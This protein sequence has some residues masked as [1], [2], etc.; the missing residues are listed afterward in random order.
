[1]TMPD[2]H[3]PHTRTRLPVGEQ[4]DAPARRPLRTLGTVLG[5]VLLLIAALAVAN[6]LGGTSSGKGGGTAAAGG[7]GDAASTPTAP[8]GTTPVTT[9]TGGI[10][11]GY[12]DDA[13]G[14]QSAAANYAVALNSTA[15]Y[16]AAPRQEIVQTVTD[17]AATAHLLSVLD[18]SFT[19][20]ARTLGLGSDGAAPAGLTFVSRPIPVGTKLDTYSAAA[21]T[22][23]VWTNGL[24][25]LAGT[26][27]TN[28]VT[29]YWYTLTFQLRWTG[30]D[31]KIESYSQKDGPVPVS[32]S[33]TVSNSD[34]ISGAVNQF[35]GF[36]Y[37][38]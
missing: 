37:A 15:M 4:T 9:T 20:A 34:T 6:R 36:R 12:H 1:M 2:D 19:S 18:A 27:S 16:A 23:E 8:S 22:V 31:W 28:P 14:A 3:Q 29:S 17:P 38:R 10:P 25:G 32:G 5:V 21:A 11:S 33:Q 35:G 13:E 7:G 26:G 30:G 24:V